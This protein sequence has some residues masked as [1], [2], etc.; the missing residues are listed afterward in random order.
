MP[1]K[2][3]NL[4]RRSGTSNNLQTILACHTDIMIHQRG[5]QS[6]SH[7]AAITGKGVATVQRV[8]S[9][10]LPAKSGKGMAKGRKI[11]ERKIIVT[12]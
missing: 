5:G 8:K 6:I 1:P 11:H 9:A 10:V 12:R 4:G 3:L 7:A 2:A